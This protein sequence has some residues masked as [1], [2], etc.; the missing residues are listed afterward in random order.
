MMDRL[1]TFKNQ[2]DIEARPH[3]PLVNILLESRH[4]KS[5][6]AS[7]KIYGVLDLASDGY[8]LV[9]PDYSTPPAE[10]FKNFAVSYITTRGNIDLLYCCIKPRKESYLTLPSWVPDWTQPCHHNLFTFTGYGSHASRKTD[11]AFRF[12]NDNQTLFVR[13]KY[14]DKIE[15][16]E[17]TR[18]IPRHP[19]EDLPLSAWTHSIDGTPAHIGPDIL[20]SQHNAWRDDLNENAR[21]YMRNIISIAYPDQ[22]VTPETFEAL[23]RSFVCNKR[24][25]QTVP[26]PEWGQHFSDFMANLTTPK[27]HRA[28]RY[29][30]IAR[31]E[32]NPYDLRES[33]DNR[34]LIE[35]KERGL[36]EFTQAYGL[37]CYNRRF[38]KT[39]AGRFGWGVDT[40]E[41]GDV[42][43]VLYGASIPFILRPVGGG[44][45]EVV[46]DC[47]VH[48]FMDG[49]A[50]TDDIEECEFHLV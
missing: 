17:K 15:A 32:R 25:D 3:F 5:T 16:V 20:G 18:R 31:V 8:G 1:R 37:W 36:M 27:S 10:V 2:D 41:P 7:D 48:E 47:Y 23:W 12:A 46:G 22:K 28:A 45:F 42:I 29:E 30:Q 38:L 24:I 21:L 9:E 50:M 49:E 19:S 26:P 44:C 33:V 13:G 35:E 43:C 6:L 40:T 34:R 11:P 39:Q 14:I 4:F